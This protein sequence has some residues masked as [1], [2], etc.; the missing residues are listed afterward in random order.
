MCDHPLL[1]LGEPPICF[2]GCLVL[3]GWWCGEGRSSSGRGG[4]VSVEAPEPKEFGSV[5]GVHQTT[6]ANERRDGH[7]LFGRRLN[8]DD[9]VL[10]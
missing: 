4:E 10:R 3:E 6:K 2:V 7:G 1:V 8:D 9:C 5:F